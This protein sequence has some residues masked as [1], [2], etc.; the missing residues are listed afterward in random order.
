MSN[1]LVKKNP[2]EGY[3]NVFPKT[4]IDAIKDK[5]S[6]VSLEEILQGFNMYFLSYNGSRA[7]TRCKIPTVLRKEGLWIT[8]VLYDHTVVTEWYNSDQIDDNSWSMD[9]NW[10][11]A[12]NNLVGD[13]SVSAD[14][15]WVINGEKTEAKAQGEQGVTPLLRIGANNKLQVS[16]N[17]GKAWKDISDYIVPRFRW[18]QG[19]GT[20]AG[21][22]QISMDLGNTWTNLS[23]EIT[24]NLRISRY[25]GINESLPT[26]EVAEGTVYMKG[27]YYDE[28]DT[29]NA[30]PIYRM[31]VY[32][33]KGN[34]L[35]WQDNGEFTSISA[36][37]VQERGNSTTE[38]M[39]QDAVTRELTELESEQRQFAEGIANN[40]GLY[41]F[42]E[43][44]MNGNYTIYV[45]VERMMLNKGDTC[46]ISID[47]YSGGTSWFSLLDK[48]SG[49]S[50]ASF[51]LPSDNNRIQFLAD[52][53]YEDLS[54]RINVESNKTNI[55]GT[56]K[57]S[58]STNVID[59]FESESKTEA[60]SAAKGKE[61]Y[62]LIPISE[63]FGDKGKVSILF[64]NESNKFLVE[65]TEELSF[66]WI[67]KDKVTAL[68]IAKGTQYLIEETRA[69]CV[70]CYTN[71]IVIIPREQIKAFHLPLLII[72]L[73]DFGWYLRL[74]GYLF[75]YKIDLTEDQQ[76]TERTRMNAQKNIGNIIVSV[77]GSGF[78][79]SWGYSNGS[80]KMR[81]AKR[82]IIHYML[83]D[84]THKVVAMEEGDAYSILPY[85]ALV[86]DSNDNVIKT[87]KASEVTM[88][89][90]VLAQT[91]EIDEYFT[92]YITGYFADRV[93][94]ETSYEDY[95]I[96]NVK[97]IYVRDVD[98]DSIEVLNKR[99][100]FSMLIGTDLHIN[101][102]L[103]VL[104]APAMNVMER[105]K[106]NCT[107]T[108]VVNL[109][110]TVALGLE[111]SARAYYSLNDLKQ[112]IS[113]LSNYYLVVGNHDY[114]NISE[115][116]TSRQP[117]ESI[118]PKS[119]I[120]N[121]MGKFHEN[122]CVWGSK[123]GMYYYKDFE[124]EKVRVI[125][126][127][128]LD[129]PEE[130]VTID[131]K[132]YEKYPWLPN[133]VSREQIDWFADVAL[134]L[135]NKS[136]RREW[137]VIVCSHVTPAP[138]VPGNSASIGSLQI[139][140][141]QGAEICKVVEAF[142]SGSSKTLSY[143]D[144]QYGGS[145][146]LNRV[147]DFSEQGA[148]KIIGWFSGHTHHDYMETINGVTY[149]VTLCGYYTSGVDGSYIEMD[150]GT[151][152]EIALDYLSVDKV[153]RKA[154]LTRYGAGSDREWN[155]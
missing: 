27:P 139:D 5:E 136:D 1:Q 113:D 71:E 147:V 124:N 6:G 54:L 143:V 14:G 9:S 144:S 62:S 13:V 128:T 125:F 31:W 149:I 148:M 97:Q 89:D 76:T 70:D 142:V 7:L 146:T 79:D 45:L 32:A 48:E 34:T 77:Y 87:K 16:Y 66:R 94:I 119:A 151:Y 2:A 65:V 35:A 107:P 64:D 72:P 121:L 39:S 131:G 145:A 154:K 21:N 117:K 130:W 40:L 116:S 98:N 11:V 33:W 68:T 56:L 63:C 29:S 26:S 81:I 155:W 112:P 138:N 118:I 19:T 15:Y 58:N 55:K 52:K 3:Q 18:N 86:V 10:R 75:P 122:D 93:L 123:D 25:I 141:P 104:A 20:S 109:G 90:L 153:Q 28:G 24:N 110:D 73:Y 23:N 95:D 92:R 43:N 42:E 99:N 84:G 41:N 137:A 152:S 61:L 53:D 80:V 103:K 78:I 4:W 47:D 57:I 69:L 129:K 44:E 60:L 100:D 140:N 88:G 127:N 82:A 126:L 36:G 38:I 74:G 132:Q 108:M 67:Q 102:Q 50:I 59:S 96:H 12:S 134:N 37:I 85:Y 17:A 133:I 150:K 91:G 106:Q 30:N 135:S 8:Y 105:I 22:V 46:T 114:N 120:Y 111:D 51:V 49:N 115:L 101:S 83:S